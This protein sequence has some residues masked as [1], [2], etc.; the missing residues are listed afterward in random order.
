MR[1]I[2][3][4]LCITNLVTTTAL[5]AVEIKYLICSSLV[6]KSDY[7]TKISKMENENITDH[8]HDKCIT[9]QEFYKILLIS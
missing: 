5:T 6:K 9:T 8:D 1:L 3:K 4:Y 7:I 2:T